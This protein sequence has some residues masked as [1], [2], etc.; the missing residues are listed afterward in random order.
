MQ[1][2][3]LLC[4]LVQVLVFGEL[5]YT[6][7]AF[8]LFKSSSTPTVYALSEATSPF[9]CDIPV[10]G[11]INDYEIGWKISSSIYSFM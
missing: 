4:Y 11:F 5:S 9:V 8:W 2:E 3:A 6:K 7:T 1:T 10:D